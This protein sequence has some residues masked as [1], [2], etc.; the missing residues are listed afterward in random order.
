MSPEEYQAQLLVALS[1]YS[2]DPYGFVL[3]SYPWREKGGPLENYDGPEL[4]QR[5]ILE[6]LGSGVLSVEEAILAA[7][8]HEADAEVESLPIR[9]ARASGHGIGKS[10]CVSWII[11]WAISTM[12]DTKGVVTANTENQL[13]TKTWAELAKWLRM[14]MTKDL[15]KMTATALFSVDP[16]H[17]KTWRIDM[18]PWSEK[19][20][21]AFAGLHNK[22]KRILILFDEAS[23]VHDLIWETTEG[24]LTDKNTQIIWVCFGNPTRNTGRFRDCFAGGK[25]EH[26]WDHA[27]ID[28]R[29]VSITNKSQIDEWIKDYGED[30]DFVRVRVLGKFPRVDADSFISYELAVAATRRELPGENMAPVVLGVDVA[31]FGNDSSVIYPRRG[32]D[33]R[34][35]K[36][37]VLRGLNTMQLA[38]RVY[39]AY[40]EHSAVA[41]FVDGGGVGGGVVDRLNQLGVPVYE[42]TFGA[43]PDNANQELWGEK[44]LNKRA[45][46]WGSL[47]NWL[48][49]GCIPD[50]V[51]LVE[52]EFATELSTPTFTISREDYIQL[53]S[54]KD[55]KRRNVASPDLSDALACTFAYPTL[56]LAPEALNEVSG[57]SKNRYEENDPFAEVM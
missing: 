48:K 6:K 35:L 44:Y 5:E 49:G 28:S 30:H 36:P 57:I 32:R 3:W 51:P 22:G 20:T 34:T 45:E 15:F 24:A 11:D 8:K 31:R 10:A 7:Q 4:W 1:E 13:K 26:R 56:E 25:F 50:K 53:E 46:I 41:V 38:T 16:D 21:E 23:A 29:T 55:M 43:K 2:S 17:E 47:R 37:Q 54:K 9:L 52:E 19:N 12:V 42:V 27:A 39:N 33:A 18:V 14:S 40:I